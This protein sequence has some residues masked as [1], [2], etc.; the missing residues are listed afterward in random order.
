MRGLLVML[1]TGS[2]L[3]E[4]APERTD[5]P[6]AAKP[7]PADRT[8]PAPKPAPDRA[9]V[10]SRRVVPHVRGMSEA[11]RGVE[12][13]PPA[14]YRDDSAGAPAFG[15]GT[16]LGRVERPRWHTDMRDYADGGM[17]IRPPWTGDDMAIGAGLDGLTS[18][19]PARRLWNAL[20]Y[21]ADRLF[22]TLLA[23]GGRT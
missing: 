19:A 4:P 13:T 2:A 23:G 17:V 16:S 1:M 22:E 18:G 12:L 21:G 10:A 14:E 8:A 5:K 6:A 11:Q 20:R 7:G 9:K 3:A 15:G